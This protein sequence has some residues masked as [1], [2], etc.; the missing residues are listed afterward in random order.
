MNN[1]EFGR[2]MPGPR[3]GW[4]RAQLRNWLELGQMLIFYI[5][6]FGHQNERAFKRGRSLIHIFYLFILRPFVYYKFS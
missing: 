6:T 4:A 1:N 2:V 5:R 3:P